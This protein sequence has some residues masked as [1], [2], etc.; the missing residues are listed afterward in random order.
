MTS[1]DYMIASLSSVIIKLPNL[2]P[3]SFSA[4]EETDEIALRNMQNSFCT[5]RHPASKQKTHIQI[6]LIPR[7]YFHFLKTHTYESI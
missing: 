1:K 7:I 6:H 4:Q 5:F 3:D 2:H